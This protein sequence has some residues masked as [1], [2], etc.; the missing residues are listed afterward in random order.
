[1][2]ATPRRPKCHRCGNHLE[3]RIAPPHAEKMK[4]DG[5][6]HEVVVENMPQWRCDACDVTLTDD[7]SDTVVQDCLRRHIGL[8][9]AAEIRE[10]RADLGLT[11]TDLAKLLGCAAESVSRWENSVVLQSRTYDRMLRMVFHVPTV[12]QLLVGLTAESSVG[13]KA[14]AGAGDPPAGV[15]ESMKALGRIWEGAS[16]RVEKPKAPPAET[17]ERQVRAR[18]IGRAWLAAH[19]STE[20]TVAAWQPLG[21][22]GTAPSGEGG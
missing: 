19:R 16:R 9:A 17:D 18:Q 21:S 3:Q 15:V 7:A 13:R 11:Q 1:M 6:T 10:A 4:Y 22:T 2:G 20:A 8:L 5:A 12:R 14:V